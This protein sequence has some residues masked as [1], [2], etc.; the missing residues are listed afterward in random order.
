MFMQSALLNYLRQRSEQVLNREEL[1]A[2]VWG[3][4][5]DPRSRVIDQ[6]VSQVRK[7]LEPGERI[8]TVHGTGYQHRRKTR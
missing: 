4:R 2:A 5:L 7:T 3:L 8:L 6:T 1:A